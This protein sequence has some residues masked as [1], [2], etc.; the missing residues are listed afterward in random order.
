V[1]GG[2]EREEESYPSIS[3]FAATNLR[4]I[5]SLSMVRYF[6]LVSA[7]RGERGLGSG[8]S[9]EEVEEREEK[10]RD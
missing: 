3:I 6:S 5:P 4:G 7:G 2:G 8:S 10:E 1:S 9:W